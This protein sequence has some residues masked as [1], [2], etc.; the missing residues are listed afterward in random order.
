MSYSRAYYALQTVL[1][2]GASAE[3]TEHE[4]SDTCAIVRGQPLRLRWITAGWPRQVADALQL[5]P[6]PDVIVAPRLSPG[7]RALAAREG[8]GWIDETGAAQISAGMLLIRLDG[9]PD[10]PVNER[11]GWRPATLTVCEALLTGCPATV[12]TVVGRTKLSM[13]TAATALKL[14]EGEGLLGSSAAR[15]PASRRQA[16]DQAQLADAYADAAARLRPQSYIR[17]GVLWRDPVAG[18]IEAGRAWDNEGLDWAVTSALTAAVLAPTLTQVTPLEIYVPGRTRAGLRWAAGLAGLQEMEGGR[19]LLRPFPTTTSSVMTD[20]IAPRL[21]SVLWPRAFADLRTA[22]VR[23][24][25]AAE[26]LRAEMSRE[27]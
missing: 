24:E 15:G 6:R 13:S 18:V 2:Q 27:Y 8:V 25:D 11:T 19:L 3:V 26:H 10:L 5:G 14:L 21:R 23:G 1:P 9:D 22:G 7:A 16:V 12:A 4:G 17:I 20:E